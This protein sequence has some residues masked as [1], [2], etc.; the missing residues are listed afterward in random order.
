[1][2]CL[3]KF[4][5]NEYYNSEAMDHNEKKPGYDIIA[6]IRFLLTYSR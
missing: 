6:T 5:G 3:M 2:S 4:F 1:M